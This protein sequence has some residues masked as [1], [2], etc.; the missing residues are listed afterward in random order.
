MNRP[1][2]TIYTRTTTCT[3][4]S[5]TVNNT[6]IKLYSSPSIPSIYASTLRG[7]EERRSSG[8]MKLRAASWEL[9]RRCFKCVCLQVFINVELNERVF[10]D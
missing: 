5:K 8:E 3:K 4:N 9:K 10:Q 1:T 2:G 6:K 7:E